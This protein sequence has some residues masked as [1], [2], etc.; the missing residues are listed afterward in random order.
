MPGEKLF[1]ECAGRYHLE[2]Q[3]NFDAFLKA[4]GIYQ[5]N[6]M[7]LYRLGLN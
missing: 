7:G 2:S 3:H 6:F 1:K 4:L 5:I